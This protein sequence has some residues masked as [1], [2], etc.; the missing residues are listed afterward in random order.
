MIYECGRVTGMIK[1]QGKSNTG[2]KLD[3]PPHITYDLTWD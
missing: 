2:G 3:P 1:W